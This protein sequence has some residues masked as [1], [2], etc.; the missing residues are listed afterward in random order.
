MQNWHFRKYS[1][2]PSV[3][4]LLGGGNPLVGGC[5]VCESCQPIISTCQRRN[6]IPAQ[7]RHSSVGWNLFMGKWTPAYAGVTLLGWGE[8]LLLRHASGS[9]HPFMKS[10]APAYAGVTFLG[11][12]DGIGLG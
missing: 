12:G 4:E 1:V 5:Y 10:W 11:W 3:V 2:I 8:A 6:V 7:E 9:W